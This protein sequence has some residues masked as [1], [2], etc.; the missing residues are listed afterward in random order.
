MAVR[1]KS[2]PTKD[3]TGM[4]TAGAR[5]A[6]GASSTGK[7]RQK[8]PSPG[9]KNKVPAEI[10]WK[11]FLAAERPWRTIISLIIIAATIFVFGFWVAFWA[12]IVA[13]LV[14]FAMLNSYFIPIN[15]QLTAE[16]VIIRKFY[17]TDK[18]EWRMFRRFFITPT[19]VVLSTFAERKRFLDNFRG[20]Q[21]FLPTDKDEREKV[22]DFI[23]SKLSLDSGQH[24]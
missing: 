4:A 8:S 9:L 12:A 10:S 20:V 1:G 13:F 19:G 17:Y 15:Y 14:F 23:E 22:L 5:R 11:V 3:S 24:R 2:H 7:K 18:R 21:L 16:K 6:A